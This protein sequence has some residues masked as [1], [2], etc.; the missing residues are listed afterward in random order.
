MKIFLL[1][2]NVKIVYTKD[3]EIKQIGGVKSICRI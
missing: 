1:T 3:R 2:L